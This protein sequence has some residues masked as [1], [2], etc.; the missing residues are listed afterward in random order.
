M[1]D[2]KELEKLVKSFLKNNNF[3]ES[4]G[5]AF[6][7]IALQE[8]LRFN[9][10]Q[11]KMCRMEVMGEAHYYIEL[12]DNQILDPFIYKFNSETIHFPHK[13]Y[14]G[15]LPEFFKEW[16]EKTENNKTIRDLNIG[17]RER[18]DDLLVSLS[19]KTFQEAV[20]ILTDISGLTDDG[21]RVYYSHSFNPATK[22]ID[23]EKVYKTADGQ[24]FKFDGNVI[25][26]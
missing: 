5:S 11:S 24:T 2:T 13:I 12:S 19:R 18:F 20:E 15:E 9:G 14:I 21:G 6:V 10:Y 23:V 7:I 25:L 16:I 17:L 1:Q 26:N 22:R 4:E 3:E 8:F